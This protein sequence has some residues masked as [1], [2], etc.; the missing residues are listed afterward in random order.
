MVTFAVF[1]AICVLYVDGQAVRARVVSENE[2]P[3]P[4]NFA[5]SADDVEG[6]HEHTATGD[7]N[8]RVQ[9]SYTIKLADGR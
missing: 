2:P 6:S 8:G 1:A 7:A 5:Y 4:F 3:T 9:G